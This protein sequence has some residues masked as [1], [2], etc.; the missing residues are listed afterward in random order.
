MVP[1]TPNTA[2]VTV[3]GIDPIQS[4]LEQL[5]E[6]RTWIIASSGVVNL[7]LY[8]GRICGAVFNICACVGQVDRTDAHQVGCCCLCVCIG[9]NQHALPALQ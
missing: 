4:C 7:L 9:A 3:C 6:N 8:S 1:A 5:L 2:L